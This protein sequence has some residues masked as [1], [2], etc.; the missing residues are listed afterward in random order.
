[1]SNQITGVIHKVL[2][3][4]NISEKF[5]KRSFVIKTQDQY[6][7]MIICECTNDRISLLDAIKTGDSVTAHINIK[8]RE[9]TNAQMEVKYFVT[10]D[11]WKIEKAQSGNSVTGEASNQRNNINQENESPNLPF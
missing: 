2:N 6:P 9:Y 11:V 4:E 7:Q 8:G 10:I 3:Q 1:M 5:K